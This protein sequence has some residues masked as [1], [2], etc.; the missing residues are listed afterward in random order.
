MALQVN[1]TRQ[2]PADAAAQEEERSIPSVQAALPGGRL[3]GV[4]VADDEPGLR[5]LLDRLLRQRGFTVWLAAD[6]QEALDVYRRQAGDIGLV[7]LD[8]NMPRVTGP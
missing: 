4:L 7:F 1:Q 2:E 8:V 3:T 6:G 5:F